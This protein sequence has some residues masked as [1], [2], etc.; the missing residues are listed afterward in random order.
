M[1]GGGEGGGGA[2]RGHLKCMFFQL[3]VKVAIR[4]ACLIFSPD[5]VDVPTF[6]SPI[7]LFLSLEGSFMLDI[8]RQKLYNSFGF[9]GKFHCSLQILKG[10]FPIRQFAT[11]TTTGFHFVG[12]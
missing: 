5:F 8:V 12:N 6:I 9:R 2:G 4:R 11:P 3:M 1:M 10:L 7:F